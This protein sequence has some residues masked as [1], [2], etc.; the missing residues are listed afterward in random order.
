MRTLNQQIKPSAINF[1]N[2]RTLRLSTLAA[3]AFALLAMNLTVVAQVISGDENLEYFGDLLNQNSTTYVDPTLN[4]INV[5]PDACVPTS[6][7]QGLSYLENYQTIALSKPDPFSVSPNNT[8]AINAL[9]AA[10]GTRENP[11]AQAFGTTYPGRVNGTTTYLSPTGAN[12][13][14]TVSVVGGQYASRYSAAANIGATVQSTMQAVSVANFLANTLNANDGVQF[15]ILWGSLDTATDVY[16]QGQG[17]HQ[18][19]LQEISYN[20]T[21]GTGTIDFI[22]PNTAQVVDGTL[23]LTTGGNLYVSYPGAPVAP[24][25]DGQ[26]E[27]AVFGANLD[28]AIPAGQVGGIIINDMAEGVPDTTLAAAL[29]AASMIGLEG[30]RRRYC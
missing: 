11:T 10:M 4:G 12:P 29:L 27:E 7:A 17:G 15:S 2:R 16:T 28:G 26:A 14:P 6:V 22:D 24:P 1:G 19:T 30:L 21:T 13:A 25:D 5:G 8:A 23:Q 3:A 9:A 18:V 20:A